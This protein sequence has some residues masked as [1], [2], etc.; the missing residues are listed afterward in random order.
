MNYKQNDKQS[1]QSE[2]SSSDNNLSISD[3]KSEN[4][5]SDK[6]LSISDRRV[7]AKYGIWGM[8]QTHDVSNPQSLPDATPDSGEPPLGR[9]RSKMGE[10]DRL[11]RSVL[12]YYLIPVVGFFPS[13][14]TLYRRQGT[15]EQM[16]VSRLSVTLAFTWLLGHLLLQTGAHNTESITLPLLLVS[17]VLTSS[18]F[19]ISVWLMIRLWQ[20]RS[21]KIPGISHVADRVVGR[22]L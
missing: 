1:R 19:V 17:S 11:N 10:P 8:D 5:A 20:R 2:N 22:H 16:T 21:L 15:R 12:F 13:L 7:R 14:W 3:Q 9:W 18:Y 6:N 4:S